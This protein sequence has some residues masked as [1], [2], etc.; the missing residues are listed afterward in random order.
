MSERPVTPQDAPAG[1]AEPS[2][3]APLDPARPAHPV[4]PSWTTWAPALNPTI[5]TSS[6][7]P[8]TPA[9]APTVPTAPRQP[10]VTYLPAP[11]GPN[12]GLVFLGLLFVLVAT[13]VVA[14]LLVGFQ[15]AQLTEM[16]PSVLVV[17]GL[18][19]AGIGAVG[20]L[21]RRR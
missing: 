6:S 13:G 21:A 12:W 5:P 11:S 15:V 9:P 19:C 7:S 20:I 16:G 3:A 4:N 18:A 14:N 2:V 8:S 10:E 17:G 1:G